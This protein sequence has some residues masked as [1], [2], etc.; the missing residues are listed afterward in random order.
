MAY[1]TLQKKEQ[2]ARVGKSILTKMK[3]KEKVKDGKKTWPKKEGKR[4]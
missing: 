3:A 4:K 1:E 2:A